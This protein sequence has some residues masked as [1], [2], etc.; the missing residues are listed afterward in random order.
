MNILFRVL[1]QRLSFFAITEWKSQIPGQG[2][3]SCLELGLQGT[4]TGNSTWTA[5]N[6]GGGSSPRGYQ[7]KKNDILVDNKTIDAIYPTF[8]QAASS[9][10][11][12]LPYWR[13][14]STSEAHSEAPSS[15][16]PS[17]T[18][19]FTTCWVRHPTF[20]RVPFSYCPEHKGV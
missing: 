13:P 1:Q 11:N 7:E 4:L 17:L 10:W 5:P 16:K 8:C 9:C 14:Y 19:T 20:S 18:Q 6:R 15:R 12:A 2:W 3:L